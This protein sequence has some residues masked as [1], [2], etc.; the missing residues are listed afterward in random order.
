LERG[1]EASALFAT[2]YLS[3]IIEIPAKPKAGISRFEL[4]RQRRTPFRRTKNTAIT[5]IGELEK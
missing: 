4:G 2:C 1:T 5:F 3:S